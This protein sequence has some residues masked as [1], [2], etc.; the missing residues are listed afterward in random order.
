MREKSVEFLRRKWCSIYLVLD[1]Q[2]FDFGKIK[3]EAYFTLSHK[4][5]IPSHTSKSKIKAASGF[6]NAES[7]HFVLIGHLGK[8]IERRVDGT[9]SKSGIS[10]KE[11]LDFVFDVIRASDALIPCRC[12]LVEF[13]EDKKVQQVYLDYQFTFFQ[14]DGEHFQFYKQI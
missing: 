12:A 7:I 2:A 9:Y 1:E 6:K 3:I 8:H 13:G 14:H 11:L 10:G 5:L 4:T